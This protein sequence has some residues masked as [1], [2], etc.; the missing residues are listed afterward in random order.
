MRQRLDLITYGTG[1]RARPAFRKLLPHLYAAAVA[2]HEL[3]GIQHGDEV[4]P[5]AVPVPQLRDRV[6]Q[7]PVREVQLAALPRAL[8]SGVGDAQG[9]RLLSDGA[10]VRRVMLHEDQK[11]GFSFPICNRRLRAEIVTR[12]A[13]TETGCSIGMV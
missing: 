3:R 8:Q 12:Q 6:R 5:A 11:A 9:V 13:S 1:V 10:R 2:D 4:A 7:R